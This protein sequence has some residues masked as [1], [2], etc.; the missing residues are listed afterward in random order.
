MKQNIV[1]LHQSSR[2]THLSRLYFLSKGC[3]QAP[4]EST[5]GKVLWANGKEGYFMSAYGVK[6][7]PTFSPAKRKKATKPTTAKEGLHTPTCA[8][9]T[10]NQRT[11]SCS[12]LLLTSLARSSLIPR[13]APTRV[14]FITSSRTPTTSVWSISWAG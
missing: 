8:I 6:Q 7:N 5:G 9:S 14:S 11:V 3:K 12:R 2:Q 10:A 1:P 13:E 4:L